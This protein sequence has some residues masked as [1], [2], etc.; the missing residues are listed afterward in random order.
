MTSPMVT[1]PM[2]IAYAF[3][4]CFHTIL[5]SYLADR[6][7]K[8]GAATTVTPTKSGIPDTWST[9]CPRPLKMAST[10]PTTVVPALARRPSAKLHG[11]STRVLFFA[12]VGLL[13]AN[14]LSNA[15]HSSA[16]DFCLWAP[17]KFPCSTL[18]WRYSNQPLYI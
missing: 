13:V 5:N 14:F 9:T 6:R 2:A 16:S 4:S 10:A 18:V 8:Y 11:S 1:R 17:R 12:T 15:I 7:F 3:H